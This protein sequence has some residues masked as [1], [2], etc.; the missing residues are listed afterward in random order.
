MLR[1]ILAYIR[2]ESTSDILFGKKE[3]KRKKDPDARA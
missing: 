1:F 3:K 2:Q